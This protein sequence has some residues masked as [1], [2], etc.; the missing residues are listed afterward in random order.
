MQERVGQSHYLRGG[1]DHP[2][3]KY[4]IMSLDARQTYYRAT[5]IQ[6]KPP[7]LKPGT[8]AM[9]SPK[10]RRQKTQRSNDYYH[11]QHS[12]DGFSAEHPSLRSVS[13]FDDS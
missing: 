13:M 6:D 4:R 2:S 5:A 12:V 3:P 1:R 10:D 7:K 8:A 11:S 9:A